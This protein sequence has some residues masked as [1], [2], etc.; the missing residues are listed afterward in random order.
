MDLA[1]GCR[2]ER[3]RR[4]VGER[5]VDRTP[6]RA[7]D[8]RLHL[9]PRRGRD[10]ALER[11]ERVRERGGQQVP[12]RGQHLA[13][14]HERHAGVA[15]GVAQRGRLS[16]L[17]G[18]RQARAVRLP[19]SARE[20]PTEAVPDA[21]PQDLGVA[22]RLATALAQPSERAPR[23]RDRAR[24]DEELEHEQHAQPEHERPREREHDGDERDARLDRERPVRARPAGVEQAAREHP[25]R[26]RQHREG[27]D[28]RAD[29]ADG[30]PMTRRAVAARSS[31]IPTVKTRPNRPTRRP[32]TTC[33][34][35]TL[36]D[37]TADHQ[38]A[39]PA[40][41]ARP[42]RSRQPARPGR[43]TGGSDVGGAA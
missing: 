10:L 33:M 36:P 12:A 25:R 29:P 27:H 35:A 7:R 42:S 31:S 30:A 20:R 3:L 28:R 1:H 21:D 38:H 22:P 13:E 37:R 23:P 41:P 4:E 17:V 6:E 15:Q 34:A 24:R 2:G 39:P 5:L 14:L 43:G 9:R 16:P 19:R 32:E 8:G 26:D 11:G 40:R 18:A